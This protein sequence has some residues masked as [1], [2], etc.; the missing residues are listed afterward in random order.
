MPFMFFLSVLFSSVVCSAY[1]TMKDCSSSFSK[2]HI[3][4]LTMDPSAP[5][6]GEFVKI[7]IDYVLDSDVTDGQAIYTAS[8][9][10]FPL[11]PT[12]EPLCPDFEHTTTP[13]PVYA[14]NVHFE[15]LIQLGDGSTHGTISATTTWNDQNANQII[16]W[17]FNVR[18]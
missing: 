17:G 14:G 10:G 4:S 12:T 6:S 13:C 16:C 9:N 8:Y 18:L 3:T 5:V 1:G 11:S 15:G 2:G 7:T